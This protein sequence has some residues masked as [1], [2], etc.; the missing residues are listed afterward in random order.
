MHH[1]LLVGVGQCFGHAG[2]NRQ[3]PGDGQQV[4]VSG[5]VGQVLALEEFR[6]DVGQVM[7]LPGIKNRHDVLMLQAPGGFGFPEKA[8][9][10]VCQRIAFKLLAQGHGFD[11]HHASDF[12]I[13]AQIEHTHRALTKLFFNL[14]AP[15]HRL[16]NPATVEQHG[17]ARVGA[18]TAQNDGFRQVFGP[19][20]F[21]LQVFVDLVVSGP[22]FVPSL[23]LVELP[24]ALKIKRQVVHVVHQCIGKGDTPETV[25]SHIELTL[26]L[27]GQTHHAVGFGR[28]FVG[29][30]SPGLGHQ[31]ALSD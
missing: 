28:L 29:F 1:V 9:T 13:F 26:A 21:G 23:S 14:I 31:K 19:V 15:Q 4:A 2:N 6:G 11:R 17:S 8:R 5:H 10:G 30:E 7:L 22:V 16:F 24:F 12:A 25:K 20:K 27:Q 3:H 18:A